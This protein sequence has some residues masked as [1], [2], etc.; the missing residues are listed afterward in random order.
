[1]TWEI[2]TGI[3]NVSVAGGL[4]HLTDIFIRQIENN[5]VRYFARLGTGVMLVFPVF[6]FQLNR[7]LDAA[8]IDTEPAERRRILYIVTA[9]Y[10]MAFVPFGVGVIIAHILEQVL[11]D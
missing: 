10:F 3:S 4:S 6:L 7:I 2:I 9:A 5:K 11:N 8:R 1:M